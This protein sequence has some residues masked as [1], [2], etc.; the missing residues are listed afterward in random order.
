MKGGLRKLVDGECLPA[1]RFLI[2]GDAG[3][4]ATWKLPYRFKNS[5]KTESHLRNALARFNETSAPGELKAAAWGHLTVLCAWNRIIP[6]DGM[7]Q[8]LSA[9]QI[10][11]L[12]DAAK[13]RKQ[14]MNIRNL[15]GLNSSPEPPQPEPVTRSSALCKVELDLAV[16]SVANLSQMIT[17]AQRELADSRQRYDAAIEAFAFSV[18]M[19]EPSRGELEGLTARA[20]ALLRIRREHQER[21]AALR[22]ELASVELAEATAAG[23][24]IRRR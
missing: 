2:V 13:R 14:Q 16:Q 11:D 7:R 19:E 3:D 4:P 21:I 15:L 24:E 18:G 17:V 8:R 12:V 9:A 6:T 22:S 10:G 20:D 1:D 5:K 23:L